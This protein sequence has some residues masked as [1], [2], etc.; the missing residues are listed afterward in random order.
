MKAIVY[1]EYGGPDVLQLKEIEKPV[2]K[3]NEVCIKVHATTVNYGDLTARNFRYMPL[4]NFNM[5][6]ALYYPSRIAFG[7]LK[8]K[9]NILGSEF[10]GVIETIGKD[11]TR[12]KPGD[13]VYGYRGMNMGAYAEYVCMPEKGTLLKMPVN[14]THTEATVFPYGAI[15]AL[16]LL[17]KVNL[18]KDEKVLINGASGSIGSQAVQLAKYFGAKVTGVCSTSRIEFVKALGA[19]TIIDYTHDDFTAGKERYDLIFDILGRSSFAGC[20]RVLRPGGRYLL[21]SFKMKQ[22]LQMLWTKIAG[23]KK[24]ICA[25]SGDKAEDLE[26]ITGLIEAGHIKAVIDRTFPL[27]QAADAHR[28]VENGNKKGQVVITLTNN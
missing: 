25:L 21:A 11:V 9:I 8:P 23:D 5:P 10:S 7:F 15:V 19:D 1:E 2:P 13:P 27:K 14:L 26:F 22:L 16:N 24:V 20:K 4:S 28:Y 17:R 3:D 12:F 6:L 18:Q